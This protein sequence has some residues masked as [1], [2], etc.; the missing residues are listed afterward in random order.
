MQQSRN[1]NEIV[2]AVCKQEISECQEK[3][4]KHGK[5]RLNIYLVIFLAVALMLIQV[6][7]SAS[8]I[9]VFIFET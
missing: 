9:F 4:L 7:F 2:W 8:E 6:S 1:W 5:L 3:Y